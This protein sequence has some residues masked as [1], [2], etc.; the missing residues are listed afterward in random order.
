MVIGG[1][2]DVAIRAASTLDLAFAASLHEAELAD[3]FFASLGQRFLRS[4][5]RMFLLSPHGVVL[6]AE[7]DAAPV[8]ILAGTTDD[9]SHFRW[10]TRSYWWRLALVGA[11]ALLVRPRLLWRFAR[12]RLRRYLR[13]ALRLR[14]VTG[15][16]TAGA[17][18]GAPR[19][20]ATLTHIA[21]LPEV[22]GLG[23]GGTLT[24]RYHQL[25]A[26]TG[27]ERLVASTRSDEY[28][29]TGFYRRLGWELAGNVRD[30]DGNAFDRLQLEL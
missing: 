3:G 4:Y 14:R 6:V 5:Y 13:G 26:A 27:A 21:V 11:T 28:G 15:D 17:K 29:A 20:T 1:S 22:R 30:V 23:I 19:V 2:E 25:A 9:V 12:T 10:V 16:A 24:E 18:L 8:G 7:H